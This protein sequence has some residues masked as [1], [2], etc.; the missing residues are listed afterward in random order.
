MMLLFFVG[1]ALAIDPVVEPIGTGQINWTTMELEITSR[2]DETVGAWTDVKIVEQDALDR[3]KPMIDD[4]A[5]RVRY[6]PK[7]SADDLMASDESGAPPDVARRLDDRL[8]VTESWR[9]RETR[10][11]SS[12][13]IEMDGVLE[14]QGWLR[15]MLLTDNIAIKINKNMEGPTGV[16]LDAR[17]LSFNPCVAPEVQTSNGDMLIHP[18]MVHPD[19]L[20]VRGPV[21]YVSDPADSRAVKRTGE[22][23]M[24]LTAESSQR[25]CK[26]TLSAA[27]S[28]LLLNSPAFGNAVASGRVVLVVNP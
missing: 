12:G 25:D 5:R 19:I 27:D 14:L 2:S 18:S 13:A 9:V 20:R 1:S 7:R 8:T 10:Y 17:H 21:L 26:L 15:E 11:L 22:H 23:P 3:L 6:D 16:L 4:A 28:N 24:F